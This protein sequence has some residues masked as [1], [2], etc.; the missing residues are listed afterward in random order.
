MVD[1]VVNHTSDEHPWFQAARSSRDSPYR[2]W[3]VWSD[4]EPPNR[5]QG[6]V[7]PGEQTETWTFDDQAGAWYFHRFY[8][9]QPDLNWS[10]PSVRAEIRRVMEFWLQLGVVGF[11][12]DAAPFVIEQTTP[13]VDPGPQ[14]FS[15]LDSW[16]QE[17]Q[18]QVGDS[19][20]L[21]EANV[22][23]AEVAKFTGSRP[24]GPTDRAQLMFDFLLNPKIWLALARRDAEP[25]IEALTSAVGCWHPVRS[26]S[27]SSATTTS[28]T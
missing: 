2:D 26:G 20:L 6:L 8:E 3:Y 1:L 5:R 9:F 17:T 4:A 28:W 13:G 21:C 7:F 19:V 11:R 16:R 10:N 12:I 27:P 15:I 14:D 22:A 23:P 24:D 18:W 25:L